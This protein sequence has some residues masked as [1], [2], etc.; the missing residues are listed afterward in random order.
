MT[1]AQH[2]SILTPRI[3]RVDGEAQTDSASS[4]WV[5]SGT[6]HHLARAADLVAADLF[7]GRLNL[8]GR[9]TEGFQRVRISQEIASAR[10]YSWGAAITDA[11]RTTFWLPLQ[12]RGLYK[13]AICEHLARAARM[14][15]EVLGK[16]RVDLEFVA[17]FGT[18]S[19]HQLMALKDLSAKTRAA[20][21]A[22]V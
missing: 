20:C 7:S 14:A 5:A 9:S 6:H 8:G 13:P 22:P 19:N 21:G 3:F 4:A 2:Y 15:A 16:P 18:L 1:T 11:P 12:E 17:T 10:T